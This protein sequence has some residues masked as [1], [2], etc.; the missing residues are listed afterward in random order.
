[1][2]NIVLR[3]AQTAL[4]PD[5]KDRVNR[6]KIHSSTSDHTYIVAQ[7]RT[8]RWWSCG[9]H[10]WIRWKHCHHLDELGLPGNHTPY[11]ALLE[12]HR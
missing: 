3:V 12:S 1:M 7:H 6:F 11:E 9:C 5:T 2:A 4:L 8:G 10:G